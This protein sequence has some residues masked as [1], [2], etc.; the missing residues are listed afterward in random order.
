MS[1]AVEWSRGA[2]SGALWFA[3]SYGIG[4]ATGSNPSLTDCAMD[5]GLMAAAAVAS[6][7]T[8]EMIA[9]EV[10][11]TTS[12]AL[13]GAYFAAAQKLARGSDD[14]LMNAGLAAANDYLV[15]KVF[16]KSGMD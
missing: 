13:T 2:V 1:S 16:S 4:M 10:T 15:E 9:W 3:V 5:G 14:Y 12:A 8:H 7:V 11:G 6:D